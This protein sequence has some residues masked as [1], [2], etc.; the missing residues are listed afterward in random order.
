MKHYCLLNNVET[1]I[2]SNGGVYDFFELQ[3]RQCEDWI[4]AWWIINQLVEHS[5]RNGTRRDGM[6]HYSFHP[7]GHWKVKCWEIE[8]DGV[9]CNNKWG[10]PRQNK[11]RRAHKQNFLSLWV[12]NTS[13]LDWNLMDVSLF[14]TNS[15]GGRD[16]ATCPS[17][18]AEISLL[19]SLVREK[20][21]FLPIASD[22]TKI[23]L[24]PSLQHQP[25]VLLL[26]NSTWS[27]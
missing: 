16:S 23:L 7:F 27:Q 2:F 11:P 13:F 12:G 17:R 10:R 4:G 6:D 14:G 9:S 8:R 26:M 24:L 19:P 21:A 3:S 1:L 15:W 22:H 20:Q 18:S 5:W 25:I